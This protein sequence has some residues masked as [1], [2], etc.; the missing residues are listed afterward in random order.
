MVAMR[1]VELGGAVKCV[2]IRSM[3][4]FQYKNQQFQQDAVS[5]VVDV[6]HGVD[7]SPL[8]HSPRFQLTGVG[9]PAPGRDDKGQPF[10]FLRGKFNSTLE[11]N[12]KK[13]QSRNNIQPNKSLSG[14]DYLAL[15]THMETGT[16]KT[17]TFINTLFELHKQYGLTHFV[18]IVPSIAI[19]EGIK[20]SFATTAA[21]FGRLY[22][23]RVE[24]HEM[25][26]A[27]GKRGRKA[28]PSGVLSF[29]Y[30]QQLT[31]LVMTS[32]S[33][34]R[35]DNI[36]N[37]EL[38]GFYADNARTPMDA[39]AAKNPVLIIDEPQR[40]EGPQTAARIQNFRPMFVLR[41]SATFREGQIK[42]L[43]YVLDSYDAFHQK[44]VKG[45][46]V[47]DYKT[48]TTES[49]FL[50]VGRILRKKGQV[51]ANLEVA[52]K[53]GNAR[54][55]TVSRE[56]ET[57]N[58][59]FDATGNS[60]YRKLRVTKIDDNEKVVTF[61]DGGE[62]R[63]G[64]FRGREEKNHTIIAEVMLRDTIDKHL[65]KEQEL[66]SRGIKCISLIFI[67][68]VKDYRDY[69]A[70]DKQGHLQAVFEKCYDESRRKLISAGGISD[71]YR[72]YLN[73]WTAAEVHG[74]YFSGDAKKNKEI[75]AGVADQKNDKARRLQQEISELILRDK[76]RVLNPDNKLRFIFAHSALREGWD[77]PNVF[78]I[79]KLRSGY[80]ETN[81]VQEIGRGL[82]IC[83]N[84]ELERQDSEV[85]GG[86]FS[87][88]NRLDVFTLGNGEF[89]GRLQVELS[90]RRSEQK[91]D[92]FM[93]TA[94]KLIEI[95]GLKQMPAVNILYKLH[96]AGCID[97]DGYLVKTEDMDEI[98]SKAGLAAQK[99]LSK[100]PKT[101]DISDGRD[102][103]GGPRT[104]RVSNTHYQKFKA[105]WKLL[106]QKV[107]YQV[108]Y[109]ADFERKAVEAI[110]QMPAISSIYV[111]RYTG[112]LD[113]EN[114]NFLME[115]PSQQESVDPV[116][117]VSDLPAR[118]FLN[119]L[120][121]KT[122][123][124]RNTVISILSKINS[125]KFAEMQKNPFAAIQQVAETITAVIYQNVVDNIRY[126]K[127]DGTRETKITLTD[128]KFTAQHYLELE[129]LPNYKNNNLWEGIAPYDSEDPE[130][131]I[132]ESA[133]AN[134]MI[135]VF[136][137]LPRA[138]NIPAPMHPNGINPDFAFVVRRENGDS[139]FYFVA[140]AKPTS[141]TGALRREEQWRIDFMRKYFAGIEA[142]VEFDVV[143]N[144]E[145]LLDLFSQTGGVQ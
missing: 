25:Q 144:Y 97:E 145:Q 141:T 67:D 133:L 90:R 24:V 98:L 135:T 89:I 116:P 111:H 62:L 127:L 85:I 43:V 33:F 132:S 100:L 55:V 129:H 115:Q 105:L 49:A 77:N 68:R 22:Q 138:V 42:N 101:P 9:M 15:D 23:Q 61:S 74:G 88:F 57:E 20:K 34:N 128:R 27:K 122:N 16:G 39:I 99:L 14:E 119:Q 21:Y 84:R 130:K 81:L 124:P 107:V 35:D 136:A 143:S 5:A 93:L 142:D 73:R 47:T 94:D 8:Q 37:Q 86:E 103:S 92:F 59:L 26:S 102:A 46:T 82:R 121:E 113:T 2:A 96:A 60:A 4:Q 64:D 139:Q 91:K 54:T 3:P 30:S 109:S 69:D 48:G 44:L 125:D 36:I 134:D 56:T 29:V 18:V 76:E 126:I 120:A 80:S 50:G 131:K 11:S 75:D 108:M 40:V 53:S 104:Y 114:K 32:H 110:N 17:F 95:F 6:F 137:K 58:K 112:E 79:C 10:D 140:E 19:K 106:H 87:T 72:G 12:L 7:F 38:E 41:Y 28:P 31:V 71:E 1:R 117:L 70:D 78:Q 83:V 52:D 51:V 66:F 118:V 123:L 45:I 63:L 65:K 13:I